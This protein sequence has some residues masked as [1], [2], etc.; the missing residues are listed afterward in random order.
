MRLG[1]KRMET[2]PVQVQ[3]RTQEIKEAEEEVPEPEQQETESLTLWQRIGRLFQSIG[4]A[5]AG[6]FGK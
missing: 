5:V 4:S 2:E 6:I 3:I 1:K